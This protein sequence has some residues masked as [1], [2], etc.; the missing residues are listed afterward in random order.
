MKPLQSSISK[1]ISITVFTFALLMSLLS[2]E[3][4]AQPSFVDEE[5]T[6]SGKEAE[7]YVR[8]RGAA[9]KPLLIDLHGGPGGTAATDILFLGPYLEEHFLV[10]YFDQRGCGKSSESRDSTL[11]SMEQ[12]VEDLD[13]IIDTLRKKFGKQKVN[14]LGSSWGSLYGF[15]YLIEDCSKVNAF[16]SMSGVVDHNYQNMSLI[17][18]EL[19]RTEELL[20]GNLSKERTNE[21]LGIQKELFRIKKSDFSDFYKDVLLL[22]HKFPPALG[23]NAY[24]AD[25]ADVIDPEDILGD[26]TKMALMN[27]T[28]EDFIVAMNKGGIV[29]KAFRNNPTYNNLNIT[30]QLKSITIPVCII[31]GE[32]DY[33]VGVEQGEIIYNALTALNEAQKQLHIMPN[34]AHN[35]PIEAP[36]TVFQIVN[37]FFHRY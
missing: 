20:A 32:K 28:R 30:E 3:R 22:K 17:N 13:L 36:D 16:V 25:T 34:V 10:A 15:L 5:I 31:Q 7:F 9:D 4:A 6:I 12:Y 2:C 14:L 18:Y 1:S 27:F 23:F 26:S 21:L 8:M 29:N 11:L 33:V 19:K 37:D 24:F 35:L